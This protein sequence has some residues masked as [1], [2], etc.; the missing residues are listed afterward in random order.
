MVIITYFG[1]K[2]LTAVGKVNL[3]YLYPITFWEFLIDE[4]V[5][6]T[7]AFHLHLIDILRHYYFVGGMPETV[8]HFADTGNGL[9]TRV[10]ADSGSLI[11]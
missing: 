8:K 9:E 7:E 3:L 2:V 5:P 6:L 10:I 1:R 11:H 4:L